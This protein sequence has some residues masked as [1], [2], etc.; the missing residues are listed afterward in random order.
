MTAEIHSGHSADDDYDV[1]RQVVEVCQK[2][3]VKF[4]I[5]DGNLIVSLERVNWSTWPLLKSKLEELGAAP[6]VR[7][8]T[9]ERIR[10][11]KKKTTWKIANAS[12]SSLDKRT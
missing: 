9:T 8:I 11:A 7:H 3:G 10:N 1:T 6:L 2:N 4:S 12:K 5:R